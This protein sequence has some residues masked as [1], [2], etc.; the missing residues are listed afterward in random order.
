MVLHYYLI[1]L[2]FLSLSLPPLT[3]FSPSPRPLLSLPLPP[4]SIAPT[5]TGGVSEQFVW[6]AIKESIYNYSADQIAKFD[7]A[8]QSAGGQIVDSSESYDPSS[9]SVSFMGFKLPITV[10]RSLPIAVI[11]VIYDMYM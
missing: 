5:F 7:Y 4:L 3:P 1:L 2:S 10:S 8:L 9:S 6:D 11:Q